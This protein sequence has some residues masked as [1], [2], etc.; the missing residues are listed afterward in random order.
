[1]SE[2]EK[3]AIIQ[4][5]FARLVN[6]NHIVNKVLTTID[7]IEEVKIIKNALE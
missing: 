7:S 1:M 4:S 5:E 2:E 6:P 3:L